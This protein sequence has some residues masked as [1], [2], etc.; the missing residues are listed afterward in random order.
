MQL[1]MDSPPTWLVSVCIST[2]YL[3]ISF[4]PYC[5]ME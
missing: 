5:R 4:Y 2:Y 3:G 1:T